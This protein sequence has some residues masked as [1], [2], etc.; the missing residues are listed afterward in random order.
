MKLMAFF[1]VALLAV[2]LSVQ[3]AAAQDDDVQYSYGKVEKISGEAITLTETYYDEETGGDIVETVTYMIVPEVELE[4]VKALEEIS[5]GNEV[6][7]EYSETDGTKKVTYIY[8]YPE[9]EL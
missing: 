6:D 4:N 2:G 7:I 9:E 8:V 5:A 1:M 3:T